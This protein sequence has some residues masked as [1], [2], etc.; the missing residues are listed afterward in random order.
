MDKLFFSS[1][2]E[3]VRQGYGRL[4]LLQPIPLREL[5]DVTAARVD[6]ADHVAHVLLRRD[7]V[8]LLLFHFHIPQEIILFLGG[9]GAEG[10]TIIQAN[11]SRKY[12]RVS[13]DVHTKILIIC[14]HGANRSRSRMIA[15]ARWAPRINTTHDTAAVTHIPRVFVALECAGCGTLPCHNACANER[16]N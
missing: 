16:C 12:T 5:H 13:I 11:K 10:T 4:Y 3:H 7:D 14:H 8:H 9:G 6:V 2:L 1:H 15:A